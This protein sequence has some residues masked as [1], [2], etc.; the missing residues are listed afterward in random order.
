MDPQLGV[1][2]LALVSGIAS[3]AGKKLGEAAIVWLL[4]GIRKIA[5]KRSSAVSVTVAGVEVVVDTES[6]PEKLVADIF[7]ALD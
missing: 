4:G 2:A 5:T 6:D 1:V 7:A 3:G